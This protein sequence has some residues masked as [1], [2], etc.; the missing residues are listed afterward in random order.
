VVEL[1]EGG[2]VAGAAG[3]AGVDF[4]PVSLAGTVAVDEE[5]ASVL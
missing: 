4:A 2:G 3:V 1:V 5:R